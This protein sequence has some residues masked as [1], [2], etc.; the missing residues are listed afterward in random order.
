MLVRNALDEIELASPQSR[1][2][3]LSNQAA[4]R[5][6]KGHLSATWLNKIKSALR[7]SQLYVLACGA[8]HAWRTFYLNPDLPFR[9][10]FGIAI[11]QELSYQRAPLT[12]PC[13]PPPMLRPSLLHNQSV[14]HI[15]IQQIICFSVSS[16]NTLCLFLHT[17]FLIISIISFLQ[18]GA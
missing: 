10:F 12:S 5:S 8:V 15:Y 14:R 4:K 6:P 11:P 16:Q 9:D 17:I 1:P 2:I 13:F 3:L 18:C 7:K